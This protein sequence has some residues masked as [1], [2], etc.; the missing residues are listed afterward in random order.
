MPFQTF[1]HLHKETFALNR[2]YSDE[3]PFHTQFFAGA[4]TTYPQMNPSYRVYELDAETL[5]PVNFK[6]FY[7]NISKA[8]NMK[9]SV[10]KYELLYQMKQEYTMPDLSPS[11]F[12]TLAKAI[13]EPAT[14]HKFLTNYYK[15]MYTYNCSASCRKKYSCATQYG[16]FVN[17]E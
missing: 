5:I 12:L 9:K 10:P 16:V 11:S 15:G 14:A 8:A 13:E 17:Q 2:G 1:G 7:L 3:K 4:M 6:S